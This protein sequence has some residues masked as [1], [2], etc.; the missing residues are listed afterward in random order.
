MKTII[1]ALAASTCM[2]VEFGLCN[3]CP[4]EHYDWYKDGFLVMEEFEYA[5][6]DLMAMEGRNKV[7][8]FAKPLYDLADKDGDGKVS[9][10]EYTALVNE[11][12]AR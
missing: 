9:L 12:F 11:Y 2:A 4:A 5:T 10:D 3:G 8:A 7:K 1:I 6:R